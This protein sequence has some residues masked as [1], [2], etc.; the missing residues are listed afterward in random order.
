VV[1]KKLGLRENYKRPEPTF[2][3]GGV[4]RRSP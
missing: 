1:Q 2:E 3:L 4:L